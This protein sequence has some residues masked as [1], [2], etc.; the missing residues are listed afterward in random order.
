MTGHCTGQRQLKQRHLRLSE[1]IN[2]I[3]CRKDDVTITTGRNK[4]FNRKKTVYLMFNGEWNLDGNSDI[5]LQ[6]K[7]GKSEYI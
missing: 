6:R 7:F 1:L 3:D 2:A 4:I 5:N